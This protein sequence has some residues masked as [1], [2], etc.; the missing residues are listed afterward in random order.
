[1]SNYRDAISD[2]DF[3]ARLTARLDAQA[4]A[5]DDD[6]LQRL[7]A[8][9]MRVVAA[10][11]VKRRPGAQ[12]LFAPAGACAMAMVAAV[13][14]MQ[15]P[16]TLTADHPREFS[17]IDLLSSSEQFEMLEDLDFYAWLDSNAQNF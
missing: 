6:T 10:A 4:A 13:V 1:M 14:L 8:N 5:L 11:P 15:T 7:A 17:E 12:W 3:A 2:D 16:V 9:R